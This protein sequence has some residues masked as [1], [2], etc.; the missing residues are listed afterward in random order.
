MAGGL[1]RREAPVCRLKETAGA[2]KARLG[3]WSQCPVLDAQ[4]IVLGRVWRSDL[5]GD[6]E[7]PVEDLMEPG[8]STYRPSIPLG[9]IAAT[10]RKGGFESVFVTT[11][12]GRWI[13]L[14]NRLDVEEALR[15]A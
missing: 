14:L 4:G 2:V 15:A 12:S 8:P 11:A 9:E 13:G 1:V 7:Q 10:M 6:P 3:G 5:N